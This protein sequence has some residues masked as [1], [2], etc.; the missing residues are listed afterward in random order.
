MI[1]KQ[2]HMGFVRRLQ[3]R[4]LS[5]LQEVRSLHVPKIHPRFSPHARTS[6]LFFSNSWF[7]R[8]SCAC[9]RSRKKLFRSAEKGPGNRNRRQRGSEEGACSSVACSHASGKAHCFRRNQLHQCQAVPEYCTPVSTLFS[10]RPVGPF[11]VCDCVWV[12]LAWTDKLVEHSDE[13]QSGRAARRVA[14]G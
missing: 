10:L 8:S 11:N 12:L 14:G 6:Y 2:Y 3:A 1:C 5:V 13:L 4:C 9:L 7:T